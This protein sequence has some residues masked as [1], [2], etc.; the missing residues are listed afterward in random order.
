VAAS[1]DEFFG[2]RA[3]PL[4]QQTASEDFSDIP[5]ALAAPYTY[6]G[7]GGIDARTY[8]AA[9]DAGRVVQEIP[10]NHSPGFAPGVQPTLDTGTQALI[11]AALAWLSR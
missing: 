1:F 9:A 2:D 7:L 8:S 3:G 10:V 4:D 5:A 11:V 6:W